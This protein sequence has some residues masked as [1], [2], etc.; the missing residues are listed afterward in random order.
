MGPF[1][2]RVEGAHLFLAFP[3]G[4]PPTSLLLSPQAALTW[5]A[6]RL[7]QELEAL[8]GLTTSLR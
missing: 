3:G 4:G 2:L 1:W 8:E 7:R 6:G 5:W